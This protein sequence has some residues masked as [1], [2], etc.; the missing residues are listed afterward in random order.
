MHE[1]VHLISLEVLWHRLSDDSL[2]VKQDSTI[3]A[4]TS[5]VV[6]LNGE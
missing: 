5:V 1:I 4:K 3:F 6:E 2:D